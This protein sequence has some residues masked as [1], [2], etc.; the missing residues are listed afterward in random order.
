MAIWERFFGSKPQQ[1]VRVPPEQIPRRTA[2]APAPK[3]PAAPTTPTNP[4]PGSP[5]AWA[6]DLKKAKNYSAL[7]AAPY[8]KINDQ[9]WPKVRL[10]QRILKEAGAAA[11]D[12]ILNEITARGRCESNLADVLL[13]IGDPR[14]VPVLKAAQQREEFSYVPGTESRVERFVASFDAGFQ[15]ERETAKATEEAAAQARLTAP[16]GEGVQLREYSAAYIFTPAAAARRAFDVLKG[17]MRQGKSFPLDAPHQIALVHGPAADFVAVLVRL[18]TKNDEG[19]ALHRRLTAWFDEAG[20]G[21]PDDYESL[22]APLPGR[23]SRGL[24]HG[25]GDPYSVLEVIDKL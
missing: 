11:V 6:E 14:A 9:W 20:A 2:D 12:P 24:K 7:A 17:A 22:N 21:V 8:D 5:E 23:L 1:P 25:L 19:V 13:D 10:A 16:A 15:K 18:P 4:A 3:W